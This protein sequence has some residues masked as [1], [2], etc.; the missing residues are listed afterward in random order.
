MS[1]NVHVVV[2]L[3]INKFLRAFATEEEAVTYVG[4]LLKTNG[5]EYVRDLS[6]SRQIDDGWFVDIVTGGALLALVRG[7]GAEHDLV[8]ASGNI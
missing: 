8:T 4:R 2:D 7:A 5:E 1:S 3:D 6:I